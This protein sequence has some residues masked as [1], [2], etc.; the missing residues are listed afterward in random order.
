M[1]SFSDEQPIYFLTRSQNIQ[2][3]D[4]L[5]RFWNEGTEKVVDPKTGL[6]VTRKKVTIK[7]PLGLSQSP[8]APVENPM[9]VAK[10]ALGKRLYFDEVLSSDG[11][12]SC[13][14]CHEPKAGYTTHTPVSTG[15]KA[16]KGGMNA[17]TVLNAAYNFLQFWDGRALSLEDQAQGPVQNPIEMFAGQEGHAW[18]E[19]VRRV[20]KKDDYARRFQEAFGTEPTRDAIAKAIATYERTVLKANSVHDRAELA[21]RIRIA[22]EGTTDTT[23]KPTDYEQVLKDAV[24]SK[25]A[26][27][28]QALGVGVDASKEKRTDAARQI[29]NGR[30][31]FFGKAQCSLCHVGDNFT[32]NQFHNLGVGV[33]DGHIPADQLGRYARLALGHKNADM[34]GA[35][36]TPPLR[37]LVGSY[38][39]MHDGHE[40]TLEEVVDFYDRGGNANEFLDVKMRDAAA[41]QAFTQSKLNHSGYKGPEVKLFGKDHKPIAPKKLN[42]TPQEKKDLVMFLRA[43]EGDPVDPMV[44]D[45]TKFP[46]SVARTARP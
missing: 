44:A 30:T 13:A 36:K 4:K 11:A 1:L 40:K 33:K 35:F 43:L 17:P 5:T 24:E 15:I 10:W 8:P 3:W 31:L 23:I 12:V 32:D 45:P 21:M 46:T 37:G 28:L 38:P 9:T 2:E 19:A 27:A 26:N 25:D 39:Y 41:E 29:A 22:D 20:R 6:C 7:V 34:V 18:P 14:L 42:L 16:Q